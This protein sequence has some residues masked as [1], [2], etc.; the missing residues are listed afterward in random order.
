[1]TEVTWLTNLLGMTEFYW[2]CLTLPIE[3]DRIYWHRLTLPIEYNRK[4][5]HTQ[6]RARARTHTQLPTTTTSTHCPCLEHKRSRAIP[7]LRSWGI[8]APNLGNQLLRFN[9]NL[10][11]SF[12]KLDFRHLP[13]RCV[14]PYASYTPFIFFKVWGCV[15]HIDNKYYRLSIEQVFLL[16]LRQ[17]GVEKIL[18]GY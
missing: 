9:T 15:H 8:R 17:G 7:A 11:K 16:L 13:F 5:P 18:F 1:M 10:L 2:H 14:W 4:Y 12:S 6:H 3:Y